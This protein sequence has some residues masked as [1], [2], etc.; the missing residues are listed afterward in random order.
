MIFKGKHF[1]N[2]FRHCRVHSKARFNRRLFTAIIMMQYF[3]WRQHFEYE[4]EKIIRR[5]E[6][7]RERERNKNNFYRVRFVV[8]Y[9]FKS[10]KARICCLK[11]KKEHKNK[12]ARKTKITKTLK[13]GTLNHV[14]DVWDEKCKFV[15]FLLK[16]I[17]NYRMWG[18][19]MM[20]CFS[21]QKIMKKLFML[22]RMSKTERER[23]VV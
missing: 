6:S 9:F 13:R 11:W 15:F 19:T 14:N 2:K 4:K 16:S 22:M 8:G 17:R 21:M 10:V 5:A 7:W 12:G 18:E 3:R 1:G 23:D 20:F